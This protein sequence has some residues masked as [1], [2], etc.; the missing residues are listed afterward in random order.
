MKGDAFPLD[1]EVEVDETFVGGKAHNMHAK[2]RKAL[3]LTGTK[4]KVAV[5]GAISP[6]GNDRRESDREYRY[7]DTG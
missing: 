4:G 6:Q 1:G 2:E 5:I 7:R 3:A